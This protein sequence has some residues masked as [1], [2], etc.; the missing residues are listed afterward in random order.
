MTFEELLGNLWG[1]LETW[2]PLVLVIF[3]AF[4]LVVLSLVVTVFVKVFRGM[5]EMDRE[6]KKR[7][8]GMWL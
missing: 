1:M 3:G 4:A 2:G 8:G 7:Q 6:R 5:N